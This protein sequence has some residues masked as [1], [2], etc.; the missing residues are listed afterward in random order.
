MIDVAAYYD[1]EPI[2]GKPK[3]DDIVKPDQDGKPLRRVRIEKP[4]FTEIVLP[5]P[6]IRNAMNA[7]FPNGEPV[8]TRARA[9]MWWLTQK[10]MPHHA[11]VDAWLKVTI[12]EEPDLEKAFSEMLEAA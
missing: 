2:E 9:V 5:E 11:P 8:K 3:S 4:T 12:E 10:V 7:Y 6:Q 1:W